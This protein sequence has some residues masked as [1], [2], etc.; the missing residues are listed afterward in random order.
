MDTYLQVTADG[1]P[2]TGK[3]G[4]YID[5]C[6][7]D[8]TSHSNTLDV[9]HTDFTD[10][11]KKKKKKKN[12]NN[13]NHSNRGDTSADI[14]M[15]D[16]SVV[17]KEIS[18]DLSGKDS[19]S[20]VSVVRDAL[21]E[22]VELSDDELDPSSASS[23]FTDGTKEQLG[24]TRKSEEVK[25]SA[26]REY[27]E[28]AVLGC[29]SGHGITL[30]EYINRLVRLHGS[31]VFQN[32]LRHSSSP[33]FSSAKT[34]SQEHSNDSEATREGTVH[35]AK[36]CGIHNLGA[37]CYLNTQLQCLVR[38]SAFVEGVLQWKDDRI[39]KSDGA[40][41]RGMESVLSS[42]QVLLGRLIAGSEATV[43]TDEF[44]KALG[45]ENTEMQDPNEFGRLLFERMHETFQ[46]SH[47]GTTSLAML[48]PRLFEGTLAYRTQCCQC[49][50]VTTRKE[51]FMDLNL[52]IVGSTYG[53]NTKGASKSKTVDLV[54][55]LDEYTSPEV[56]S[57][58]NQ[59]Y[60]EV[61]GTKQDATR[62]V[63][64]ESSPPVLNLQ[65][66]RYVFDRKKFVK[67][68]LLDKV[69]LPRELAIPGDSTR[70]V[71]C[72]VMNHKGTSA[73]RGHYVAEAMDWQTGIWFEFN[74]DEVSVLSDGPTCSYNVA[75]QNG[76]STTHRKGSGSQDVYNMYYVQESFM[77]E[78]ALRSVCGP[79]VQRPAP[80][81]Q[82]DK[83]RKRQ[84]E[85]LQE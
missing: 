9:E 37:T 75:K 19:I 83:E 78:C 42:L 2:K 38:N 70:Y 81:V 58:E 52:P 29:H 71:L 85:V 35:L 82:V 60:C 3:A 50:A 46:Q 69:V 64:I 33:T 8:E 27:V 15:V 68:K 10:C 54:D 77:A 31:M 44:S 59:Y 63:L 45:L 32:P 47:S 57:A 5:L 12:N 48:L 28:A 6:S 18:P 49:S 16:S 79:A 13:N 80:L 7:E 23:I 11:H 51:K 67:K 56:L 66:S 30:D 17:K 43:S 24:S 26:I 76:S 72:A 40:Q 36:P 73:Y 61:C 4:S 41:E 55:C 20:A 21:Q 65:L 34:D 62:T 1:M 39:E 74:D 25:L 53:Q 84:W 14:D 22:P